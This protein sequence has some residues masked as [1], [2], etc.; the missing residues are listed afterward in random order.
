MK[1]HYRIIR[2]VSELTSWLCS[3]PKN[4]AV[5]SVLPHRTHQLVL[6]GGDGGEHGLGKDERL[7]VLTLQIVDGPRLTVLPQ[8]QVHPRLVPVHRVQ[9]YLKQRTAPR[10]LC[11]PLRS[12]TYIHS[13]ALSF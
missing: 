1:D 8:D 10:H 2:R 4:S 5:G 3:V 6:V 11:K 7:V 9:D 12:R 13:Y